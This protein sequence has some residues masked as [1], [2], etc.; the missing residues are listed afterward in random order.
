MVC[1]NR[2]T[3]KLLVRR[4][5]MV[6]SLWSA[7]ASSWRQQHPTRWNL[8]SASDHYSLFD[9][10]RR[11]QRQTPGRSSRP[12][13]AGK[14]WRLGPGTRVT[15][16]HHGIWSLA[17]RQYPRY[18]GSTAQ[19]RAGS[20]QSR[21]YVRPVP[22]LPPLAI[23]GER[24]RV[25]HRTARRA[26]S[27][28]GLPVSPEL[29]RPQPSHHA[30]QPL[31]PDQPGLRPLPMPGRGSVRP[32]LLPRPGHAPAPGRPRHASSAPRRCAPACSPAPP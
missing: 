8:L 25:R 29:P 3:I 21:P 12:D 17:D 14:P 31:L 13:S 10:A 5:Q 24:L 15:T 9:G 2:V 11:A 6:P 23:M 32:R 1:H 19:S 20:G 18:F 4:R 30:G 22:R 16:V 26:R 27:T 7:V 28:V